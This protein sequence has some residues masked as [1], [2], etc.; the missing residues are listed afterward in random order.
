[1]RNEKLNDLYCSPD[2][3][4]W[5]EIKDDGTGEACSMYVGEEKCIGG[6]G[7]EA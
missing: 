3:I 4:G 1:M 7:K 6:F 2:I 5:I